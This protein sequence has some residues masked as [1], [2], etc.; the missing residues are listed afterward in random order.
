M[1]EIVNKNMNV[2]SDAALVS[3]LGEFIRN[4][5]LAQNK[6]QE[7]LAAMAGINR[8]T[9]V[10]FESGKGGHLSVFIQLLRGLNQL[11][12]LEQFQVKTELSPLQ[13]ARLEAKKRKRAGRKPKTRI[14]KTDW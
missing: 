8:S 10:K 9:L 11:H 3:L 14:H 2:L 5:R 12:L 6:T 4:Q 1:M 7:E 13:I